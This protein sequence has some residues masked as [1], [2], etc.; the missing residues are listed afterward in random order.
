MLAFEAERAVALPQAADDR[1]RLLECVRTPADVFVER[2]PV[3][4]VLVAVPARPQLHDE[5][6]ARDPVDCHAGLGEQ[7][8]VAERDWAHLRADADARR[9]LGECRKRRPGIEEERAVR[10]APGVPDVAL[11]RQEQVVDDVRPIEVGLLRGLRKVD[12]QIE[13]RVRLLAVD[14][15]LERVANRRSCDGQ[16]RVDGGERI[17]GAAIRYAGRNEQLGGP[18]GG[19]KRVDAPGRRCRQPG[20]LPQTSPEPSSSRAGQ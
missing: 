10:I 6:A 17:G 8:G 1:H 15:Q 5:P 18:H 20:R 7:G 9:R 3:R 19:R 12:E 13:R 16:P 4:V 11:R 2:E 14:V